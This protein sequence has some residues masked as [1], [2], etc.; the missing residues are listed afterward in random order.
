MRKR[1]GG[2][3]PNILRNFRKSIDIYRREYVGSKGLEDITDRDMEGCEE[4]RRDYAKSTKRIK[5]RY[6]QQFKNSVALS[7]LK[8]KINYF[9]QFLRWS[10]TRYNYKGGVNEWKYKI[11]ETIKNRREAFSI[12][13]YRNLVRYMRNNKYLNKGK[14]SD[15]G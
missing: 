13:Q 8:G 1:L 5:N 9:R 6:K 4:F 11:S 14:H 12:D 10:A 15:S 7:T 2:Y 3:S